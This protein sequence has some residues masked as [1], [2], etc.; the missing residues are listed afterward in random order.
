MTTDLRGIAARLRVSY[1]LDYV[2]VGHAI[3]QASDALI[4]AAEERD[5]LRERVRTVEVNLGAA[6][7]S[8]VIAATERDSLREA[9]NA[10]QRE[11]LDL[12]LLVRR[13]VFRLRTAR[14]GHD[15]S[16][17]DEALA[18]QALDYLRRHRLEGVPLRDDAALRGEEG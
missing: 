18:R 5:A 15:I 7:E 9:N 10:A 8:A 16:Q 14:P 6:L 11:R 1:R 17:G 3:R 4:A 13:L 2:P 12:S